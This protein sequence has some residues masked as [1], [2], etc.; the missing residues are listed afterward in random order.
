MTQK[1]PLETQIFPFSLP[2]FQAQ[3][4]TQESWGS[5]E[6]SGEVLGAVAG[7]SGGNWGGLGRVWGVFRGFFP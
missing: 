7:G 5:L 4:P 3:T 2:L 6:G 1:S